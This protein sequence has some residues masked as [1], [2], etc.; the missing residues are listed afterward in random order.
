MIIYLFEKH[1]ANKQKAKAEPEP[2]KEKKKKKHCI[3]HYDPLDQII[4]SLSV[5]PS[6]SIHQTHFI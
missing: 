1:G 4:H 2:E 6:S 3:Y 5:P